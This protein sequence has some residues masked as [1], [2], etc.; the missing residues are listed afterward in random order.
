MSIDSSPSHIWALVCLKIILISNNNLVSN[1]DRGWG[2]G[3][4]MWGVDYHIRII[5][6]FFLN[7]LQQH[8][9]I[10]VFM[11]TDWTA[12]LLKLWVWS[13]SSL[14][15]M[16]YYY[17]HYL[18]ST[19]VFASCFVSSKTRS[20]VTDRQYCLTCSMFHRLSLSRN[21]TTHVPCGWITYR[22]IINNHLNTCGYISAV[23]YVKEK[24]LFNIKQF[25]LFMTFCYRSLLELLNTFHF[26]MATLT[27]FFLH[28]N[29]K[30]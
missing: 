23:A 18:F 21:W 5:R 27:F 16:L 24:W 17:Y 11:A 2:W 7:K 9:C 28:E 22:K 29:V 4:W 3:V 30:I 10:V 25:T 15:L 6:Y 12:R 19:V 13:L 20:T 8:K 26:W 1:G 14:L